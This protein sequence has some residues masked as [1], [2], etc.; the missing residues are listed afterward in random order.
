MILA[1][2]RREIVEKKGPA[3]LKGVDT[4]DLGAYPQTLGYSVSIM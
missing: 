3:G 1:E 4:T 2:R